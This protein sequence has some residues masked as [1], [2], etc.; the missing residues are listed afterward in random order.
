MG[1]LHSFCYS[2]TR[3]NIPRWVGWGMGVEAGLVVTIGLVSPDT[4]RVW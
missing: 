4:L 3:L 1:L 2:P